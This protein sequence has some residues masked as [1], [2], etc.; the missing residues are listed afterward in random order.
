[1]QRQ[2]G[3]LQALLCRYEEKEERLRRALNKL[4]DMIRGMRGSSDS[5]SLTGIEE[6]IRRLQESVGSDEVMV[7]A[8]LPGWGPS[9]PDTSGDTSPDDTPTVYPLSRTGTLHQKATTLIGGLEDV[10]ERIGALETRLPTAQGEGTGTDTEGLAR[11]ETLE[12]HAEAEESRNA[13]TQGKLDT[14]QATTDTLATAAALRIA[15]V[16]VLTQTIT[17]RCN[18]VIGATGLVGAAVSIH[19][20]AA[21]Y[22]HACHAYENGYQHSKVR[23]IDHNAQACGEVIILGIVEEPGWASAYLTAHI[24]SDGRAK[25]RAAIMT[26]ANDCSTKQLSYDMTLS[27]IWKEHPDSKVN[28]SRWLYLHVCML[29]SDGAGGAPLAESEH[30]SVW[31]G[32]TWDLV[33]T[34]RATAVGDTG[35]IAREIIITTS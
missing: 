1:M 31:Q 14:L 34:Q 15:T 27:D 20:E 24:C 35:P 7:R 16:A 13:D 5:V 32:R 33:N 9:D 23:D 29:T 8:V 4:R 30:P 11:Q 10:R 28:E 26:T 19:I 17:Q 12:E 6:G 22:D 21:A 18:A 2:V 3:T 25:M